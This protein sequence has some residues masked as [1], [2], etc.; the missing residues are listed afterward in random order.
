MNLGRE[1]ATRAAKRLIMLPP[2]APAAETCGARAQQSAM[3]VIGFLNPATSA[4]QMPDLL[5]A[6]WRGLGETGYVEGKNVAIEYRFTNW[7]PELMP[8]LAGDLVRRNV[9]VIA[10]ITPEVVAVVRN[11][12]TIHRCHRLGER[13]RCE[14]ICQ[15]LC[16]PGRQHD[17]NVS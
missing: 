3:P 15:E 8:E 5:A 4:E 1:T 16:A 6:F 13:S 2:F 12:T 14:R 17:G 7:R 9:N 11:A 10:A